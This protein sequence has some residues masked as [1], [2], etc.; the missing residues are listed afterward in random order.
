LNELLTSSTPAPTAPGVVVRRLPRSDYQDTWRKMREFTR[1]RT[2]GTADEIWLLEHPAV[3]TLG[4]A[5]KHEHLLAPGDIPVIDTDRGGQVTY[6]GP[7]QLVMYTLIDLKRAQL[8]IRQLV[9]LL[10]KSV[11]SILS[12]YGVQSVPRPDAPG[13]Y[14]D[15]AKIAALGLRVS[16]GRSYHG[17]ALNVDL[18]L[19]PFNRINPCGFQNLEVTSMS[20]LGVETT[21]DVIGSELAEMF[22]DLLAAADNNKAAKKPGESLP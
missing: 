19:E 8:G 18:D 2:P 14:V 9:G 10:E 1:A 21:T 5:G 13:V 7:G 17:L 11:V 4:Q 3:F 20:R 22:V 6:H 16:R 12:S 15:G